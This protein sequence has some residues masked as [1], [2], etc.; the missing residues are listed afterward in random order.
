MKSYER[1]KGCRECERSPISALTLESNRT[2]P[3][4]MGVSTQSIRFT[5]YSDFDIFRCKPRISEPQKIHLILKFFFFTYFFRSNANMSDVISNSDTVSM[6]G[7]MYELAL[8]SDM[9]GLRIMS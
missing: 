3:T 9:D 5:I 8:G 6:D 2:V 4:T 7:R 1:V